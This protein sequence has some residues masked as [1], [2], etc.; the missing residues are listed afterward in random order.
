MHN[1][2]AA[3]SN[4]LWVVLAG[5]FLTNALVAEFMGVKLFSL[6]RTLGWPEAQLFIFG[7]GPLAFNLTAGVLL[8][9]FVFLMTDVINEYFGPRG[10]RVLSW[11]T[12]AMI[13][14]GFVMLFWAIGLE[15]ASFWPKSH[16]LPSFSEAE[17]MAM[18]EKV[19]DYNAAYSLVFSQ[20][21]WIIAGSLAAFLIGQL[22]HV[23]I[24]HRNKKT[25]GDQKVWLR[26]T[27]STL[28]SQLVDSFVVVFIAFYLPGKWTLTQTVSLAVLSYLYKFSM[29][30]LLT[31]A[32]YGLH[33]LIDRWLGEDL[34]R[35]M[36]RAAQG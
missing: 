20:S 2:F 7:Q 22:I 19:G 10:V 9:P 29:A 6:E 3:K 13:G 16:L 30:V 15:P 21:L 14:Y 17:K 23:A 26:A 4:R 28:V 36:K 18:L 27:G 34:A 1:F 24:F 8:W 5:F 33:F 12:A 35:E 31:P 25:T 32:V 11:L